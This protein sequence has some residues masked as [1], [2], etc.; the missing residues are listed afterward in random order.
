M[1]RKI[2]GSIRSLFGSGAEERELDEELRFH[3]EKETEENVRRG[4]TPDQARRAALVRFGGVEKT[5][6]EIARGEPRRLARDD[7]AG[8]PLRAAL[9]AQESGLRR[10]GDPDAGARHRRE[11]R[12]LLG[13][14]RRPAPVAAVRRRATVS[15][16]SASTRRARESR[17]ARSRRP[18]SRDI[19]SAVAQLRRRGR[20][21]LDV[22]RAPRQG[23]ARARPDR[24]RLGE[25]LRPARRAAAARPDVSA[26][27]GQ[28]RR[29]GRPR[30]VPRLLDAQP[31]A[32]TRR[33]S[34]ASS[35]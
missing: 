18:R 27:R 8:R 32:A 1:L 23:R 26:G 19:R 11:H 30:A 24:R 22:V 20:V 17:T 35:R 14:P 12:D 25:L 34:G 33:W 10:R 2:A 28:A 5:K 31:S 15:C 13:R 4:M 9:A 3:I 16:G 29:G 7:P 21:P 6:D